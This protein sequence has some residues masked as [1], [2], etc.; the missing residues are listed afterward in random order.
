MKRPSRSTLLRTLRSRMGNGGHAANGLG[1]RGDLYYWLLGSLR[2][3]RM[4]DGPYHSEMEA[5]TVARDRFDEGRWRVVP[6]R[7]RD[8]ARAKQV[9][10]HQLVTQDGKT[11]DN[12]MQD[13]HRPTNITSVD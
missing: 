3:T 7:T 1:E 2:G 10:R 13:I 12:A 9:L 4:V 8:P 11:I 5:K 6:L